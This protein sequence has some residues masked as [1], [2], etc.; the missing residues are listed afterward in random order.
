VAG[1]DE[2]VRESREAL[3]S[4]EARGR[5]V[6]EWIREHLLEPLHALL[7]RIFSGLGAPSGWDTGRWIFV[8]LALAAIALLGY[9][10]ILLLRRAEAARRGAVADGRA[11]RTG[12]AD[13]ADAL[14]RL[15]AAEAASGR[16]VEAVRLLYEALLVRFHAAAGRRCD[17]SRTPG[18]HLVQFRDHRRYGELRSFVT[19]YQRASFSGAFLD[20]A[21]YERLLAGRPRPESP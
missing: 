9:L 17:R 4:L 12:I 15:A 18:E 5:T 3:E 21:G 1:R 10:A 8:A 20:R 19:E 7:R 16:F 2:I 14:D 11:D 13:D 6:S